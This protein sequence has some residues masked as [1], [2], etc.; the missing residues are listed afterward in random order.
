MV[1]KKKKKEKKKKWR[2]RPDSNRQSSVY[3]DRRLMSYLF[4]TG[5]VPFDH[6][7]ISDPDNLPIKATPWSVRISPW[8]LG[9]RAWTLRRKAVVRCRITL[10]CHHGG[11]VC[12]CGCLPASD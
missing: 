3:L 8:G 9:P 5:A 11:A 10:L 4:S 1:I 7:D 6:V 2:P 12:C